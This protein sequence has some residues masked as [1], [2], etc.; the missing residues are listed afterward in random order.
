MAFSRMR[1]FLILLIIAT[2]AIASRYHLRWHYWNAP[3]LKDVS[4]QGKVEYR[5]IVA[6]KKLTTVQ[7]QK[8]MEEWAK[9]YH[10][11]VGFLILSP[12]NID[13]FRQIPTFQEELKKFNDKLNENMKRL[14]HD[15]P[16]LLASLPAAFNEYMK[17]TEN[18]DKTMLEIKQ[19]LR[20]MRT[21]NPDVQKSKSS[22]EDSLAERSRS[23]QDPFAQFK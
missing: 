6:D 3:F 19:E 2:V 22:N 7:E 15:I 18:K 4:G 5:S 1:A 16:K 14:K 13:I 20:K 10:R 11:T 23:S 9:K 12:C 8:Q 21:K 17:I